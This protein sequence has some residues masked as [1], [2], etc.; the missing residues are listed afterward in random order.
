M[1]Q[2][3][4]WAE[5]LAAYREAAAT[6]SDVATAAIAHN[7][8]CLVLIGMTEPAAALDECRAALD[9]RRQLGDDRGTARTLNNLG[10]ALRHLGRYDEAEV[11]YREAL[12]LNERRGDVEA[13]VQNRSNLG[14]LAVAAGRYADAMRL[15]ES[16]QELAAGQAGAPWAARQVRIARANQGVVLE[17]LGAYREALDLYRGLAAEADPD[18]PGT[19]ASVAVNLGVMYRNLGDPVEA[20]A[21][22]EKGAAVYERLGDTAGLS[23]AR[24]NLALALHLNL[25][26]LAEAEAVYRQA[27]ALARE[28]GDRAEEIQDLYYLGL[29]ELDLG[30][31]GEAADDFRQCLELAAASGSAEG[32]WS[33]LYGLGR[34][35]EARGDAGAALAGYRQAIDEIEQVRSTLG[36]AAWRSGYFGDKR[37]VYAAAVSVLAAL[38]RDEPQA[39][40][41]EAALAV[42]ERAKA[43]EL[44]D[45]LGTPR[46]TPTPLDAESLRGLIGPGELLLEYFQGDDR[47]CLWIVGSDGVR[48]VDLGPA[49]PI[50]E[51]VADVHAALA[52]GREPADESVAE[53]SRSLLGSVPLDGVRRL[54]VAPDGKLFYL[55]FEILAGSLVDRVAVSYLP[56]GSTLALLGARRAESAGAAL[57]VAGFADPELPMDPARPRSPASLLVARFA[58]DRLPASALELAAVGHI[59]GGEQELRTGRDATEDAFRQAAA[60]GARV[61]HLATHTVV[62]ERPGQGAVVVLAA[63]EGHDGLLYPQEIA[64]L[65]CHAELTV[66]SSCRSALGAI[67]DGRALAS[68]TG[69]FLAAGSSAVVATLWDVEDTASAVFME[70]FYHQLSR[71]F[72]VAEALRRAKLRL[73][74]DPRWNRSSLWAAYALVGDGS[75]V[76][77]GRGIPVRA[78]ALGAFVAL[79]GGWMVWRTW[80]G[81]HRRPR[82]QGT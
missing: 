37:P 49:A 68:L 7:N 34:V 71:G 45:S 82:R 26:R 80:L 3:G 46:A 47:L 38:H 19:A 54:L 16:A 60:R 36:D 55:P 21:A 29:L 9:L 5:A 62:D 74:A 11:A 52:A 48:L 72:T 67:E 25:R 61:M 53:L 13:Q 65:E 1:H 15:H 75:A 12:A 41:G 66:L 6:T 51:R 64:G 59:L 77:A 33:G 78:W 76:V 40:H 57:R 44:L 20:V 4:R 81:D 18:D 2:Q 79:I 17:K 10:L 39:G 30:R 50:L 35:A 23:N 63:G 58:F 42:V 73:R 70:Q 56:S 43:R 31:D 8:A 24:L 28:G 32:R 69:A 22:F 27:L 14:V